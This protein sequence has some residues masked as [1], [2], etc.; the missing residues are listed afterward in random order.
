MTLINA[1]K[2]ADEMVLKRKQYLAKKIERYPATNFRASDISECD[3]QMVYS[4]LNWQEKSMHDEGLQAIFDAGN[5]EEENVKARL[6]YDLGFQFIE[7]QTPFEIKNRQSELI[8]RGRIDGKV[9]FN[10]EAIPIEIKSMNENIFN[11]I[12]SIDDF[13]KKQL[14]RKYLKQMQMYLYGN[15]EEAGLFILSNFRTEKIIPVTLDLGDCE[16]ILQKL[17]RNWEMVKKKQYP[18]PIEYRKDM[19]GR[20]PY[21]HICLPAIN[22][23]GA[24]FI[25]NAELEA[26]LDRRAEIEPIV[27]EYEVL[28]KEI[29]EPFKNIPE[30]FVGKDWRI[31]GKEQIRKSVDT[32]A[33]PEEVKKQ[34]QKESK[35]WITSIMRLAK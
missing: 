6:G 1:E 15:N 29:K 30:A 26:K 17:E 34:Y 35:V 19:C 4:I 7:Q 18:E 13:Q 12:K 14:H 33:M 27:D 2:L 31:V 32:K 11:G 24:K 5:R 9:L 22:N 21:A 10:G 20:C 23:E 25:D 3:R 8:C 28:D 16:Q